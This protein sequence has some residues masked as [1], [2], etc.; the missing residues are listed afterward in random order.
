M[1]RKEI[2]QQYTGLYQKIYH[3]EIKAA[4]DDLNRRIRF[5]PKSDFYYQ[6]ETIRDNYQNLL[7]YSYEGYKDVQQKKILDGLCASVLG[8]TDEM[9]QIQ[10]APELPY[11]KTEKASLHTSLGEDPRISMPDLKESSLQSVETMF[12]LI[13]LTDTISED[14]ALTLRKINDSPSLPWHEKCLVVS[15]LTLSLLHYFDIRK[16]NL[17]FLF[18]EARENQ[19]YQRA[20]TGLVLALLRYDERIRF[21]PELIDKL[22]IL[23]DDESIL[24]EL[25]LVLFQHLMARETD[26]ITREF[27]TEVLPEMRKMMPEIEEK[28][29]LGDQSED[30]DMEGKNP[31]WKDMIEEVPGLFEKIEKFS[32]MQMEGG[33]VFMSTFKLLKRFDFFN[34]MSNWFVPFHRE[35]PDISNLFSDSEE[36]N[37][38]LLESLEKAFYICNSDKYS[39]AFNFQAIP[40]QQ[41]SMI[42]TNF[43][44][45]FAQMR[46]MA[47]EEEILD[48]SLASNAIYIQ[49]IQD[50]Y[51]FFK[52]FPVRQ[53]FEDIFT[54]KIHLSDLNF[55]QSIFERTGFT[56]KIASFY[57]DKDYY[58]EAIELYLYLI[59]KNGPRGDY[60][61]KIGYCYQ[62]SDNYQKA[63]A[64]YEKAELFDT[65]RL[66]LLKKLGWCNIKMKKYDKALLYFKE[67]ADLSPEDSSLQNQVAQCYLNLKEYEEA[68]TVYTRLQ[69]FDPTSLKLLRPIAYCHFVL[70]KLDQ[71]NENYHT[72]LEESTQPSAYDLMNAAHVKLCRGER[73]QALILYG[74]SFAVKSPGSEALIKAFDEDVPFLIKHGISPEEIPLIRDYLLYQTE[75]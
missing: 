43:E 29:Q 15:A 39:F 74:Q 61:E 38:R 63:V 69:F 48:Q 22:K 2:D 71:A 55:Y 30:E 34:Y 31:G 56:E 75:P 40:A 52:L 54:W 62:K 45:E 18:I 65:N 57:F 26:R 42:V 66:W 72:L 17:L 10:L 44:A 32:K 41:R 25:E 21:Y 53:E 36:I 67:A 8:I 16:F 58:P 19:V 50:L 5:I 37:V 49:Y 47:S 70:G 11:R 4:L 33:D 68:L 9:R 12:K 1:T 23:S 64:F 59:E 60:Y 46:E 27:E 13:W 20:L 6:L 51:R 35:H 28:L 7:R 3:L 24:P 73:K 14:S